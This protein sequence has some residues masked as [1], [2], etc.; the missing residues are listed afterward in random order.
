MPR[1]RR[2]PILIPPS[3]PPRVIARER[4][5]QMNKLLVTAAVCA[6]LPAAQI[7]AAP[8]FAAELDTRSPFAENQ[9]GA[10]AGIRLRAD[11][12]ARETRLRGS[13]AIAPTT[14]NR[15]GSNSKMAMGEGLELSLAPAGKPEL[16]LAG[17][18][19]DRMSLLGEDVKPDRANMS[20]LA[21]VA[22]VAGVVVVVGF[23]AFAHVVSEAS[24]FHG[25]DDGDC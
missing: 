22:I 14:H 23:V 7:A 18:R 1:F 16:L 6:A 17:Q 24:C 10:F 13:L 25:G 21:K 15:R 11:V 19:L 4:G 5:N 20:T 3:K 12:G 9:R 8:A 2:N